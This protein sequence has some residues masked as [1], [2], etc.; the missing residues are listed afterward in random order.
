M[1][2]TEGVQHFDLKLLT[3]SKE[4]GL[5]RWRSYAAV[6]GG[7]AS[8]F[9]SYDELYRHLD[10]DP[11][12]QHATSRIVLHDHSIELNTTRLEALQR[13]ARV[14]LLQP[15]KQQESLPA[16]TS[17]YWS[18]ESYIRCSTTAMLENPIV[19][20]SL[21]Q[22]VTQRAFYLEQL[23]RWGY[24]S[25]IWHESDAN[26]LAEHGIKFMRQLALVGES[27]RLAEMFNHF[28]HTHLHRLNLVKRRVIFGSDG[29]LVCVVAQCEPLANFD[30]RNAVAELE[31]HEFPMAVINQL[32]QGRGLEIAGLYSPI[33][34]SEI[35]S[36][37]VMMVF[38]KADVALSTPNLAIIEKAG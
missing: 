10:T 30:L 13:L 9:H 22:M 14:F 21:A 6:L 12:N 1:F 8:I 4:V 29:L 37:R 15:A 28:L 2:M 26:S 36:E 34:A 24:S 19:R 35:A 31:V 5:R 27:R 18:A 23:L 3:S 20:M 33:M 17:P 11:G 25:S 32:A 7:S 38:R 16:A